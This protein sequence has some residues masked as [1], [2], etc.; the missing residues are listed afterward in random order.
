VKSF[1]YWL[2]TL[3]AVALSTI[4]FGQDAKIHL[5]YILTV[6]YNSHLIQLSQ[7]KALFDSKSV[8]QEL[9][10]PKNEVLIAF[11][12]CYNSSN[13]SLNIKNR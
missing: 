1:K 6:Q 5:R 3:M 7:V 4:V 2:A 12:D 9:R 10:A 11:A 13:Y 8:F